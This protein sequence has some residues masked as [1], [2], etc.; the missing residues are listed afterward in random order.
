MNNNNV[1]IYRLTIYSFWWFCIIMDRHLDWWGHTL[2]ITSI[3]QH[4]TRRDGWKGKKGKALQTAAVPERVEAPVIRERKLCFWENVL[5]TGSLS[6]SSWKYGILHVSGQSNVGI[7]KVI[8]D[9]LDT[10]P[11]NGASSTPCNTLKYLKQRLCSISPNWRIRV[12][13]YT[14]LSLCIE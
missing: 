13:I 2:C 9:I 14:C 6:K 7:S 4:R 3:S 12:K 10:M 11:A 1:A 8:A 5:W